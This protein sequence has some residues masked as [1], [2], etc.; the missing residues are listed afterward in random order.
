MLEAFE[1]LK[2]ANGGEDF[3]GWH[4]SFHPAIAKIRAAIK[5]AEAIL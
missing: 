3:T 4:D 2:T 1:T 5:A